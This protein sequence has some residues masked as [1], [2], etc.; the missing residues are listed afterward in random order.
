MSVAALVAELAEAGASPTVIAIAVRAVEAAE[1]GLLEQ[2][3]KGAAAKARQRAA[4][5]KEISIDLRAAVMKRDGAKCGYCG[6][7]TGPF[8]IDHV[9]PA[10]R[11]G[12]TNLANLRVSCASCNMSKG[13]KLLEEWRS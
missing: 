8:H 10:I 9:F 12:E 11:G 4:G 13:S 5:R 7:T 6:D 3:A 2:K 1:K